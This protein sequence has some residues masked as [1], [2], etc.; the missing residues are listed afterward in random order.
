MVT[1]IPFARLVPAAVLAAGAAAGLAAP[2]PPRAEACP[3]IDLPAAARPSAH[4]A[5]IRAFID[6]VTGR[7]RPATA[8]ERRKLAAATPRD[9]S[10]RTYEMVIRPDGTRIVELDDAF[11]MSVVAVKN[12]DGTVSYRCGTSHSAPAAPEAKP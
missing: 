11:M 3:P 6:P 12:P 5:A 7:L 2:D 9:R 1:R 4:G 10:P 8:E